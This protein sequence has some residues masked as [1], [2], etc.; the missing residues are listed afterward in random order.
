MFESWGGMNGSS[1][2]NLL[3]RGPASA[4]MRPMG[5]GAAP[6]HPGPRYQRLLMRRCAHQRYTC[7]VAHATNDLNRGHSRR[8]V[9]LDPGASDASRRHSSVATADYHRLVSMELD[10]R[11]RL[12]A[13]QWLQAQM[14]VIGEVL[15]RV[16][17]AEGFVFDGRRV[18]LLGP[19]GIF[20]PA[21]CDMPLSITTS[22]NGPYA[23][24]WT[25]DNRL[26]YA[27]RGTDPAHPDNRG[28]RRAM[29]TR[30]PLAYF[31]GIAPGQ[32]MA[33]F[34][35]YIVGDH[36]AQLSFDVQVDDP[37]HLGTALPSPDMVSEDRAA[38]RR[39]YVTAVVRRRLHQQA[40]RA[41]VIEAYRTRCAFCRLRHQEL[42]DAAHITADAAETGEPVVSN[43][44]ALCKLHHAAFDR[45]FLT[46]RPDYTIEVRRSILDEED[47]PMLLHGLKGMHRQPIYLP[48]ETGLRPDV[49]RLA[50]RYAAFQGAAG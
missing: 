18:P 44:L 22:P 13:F 43:G 32:Y 31:F 47:G 49:D 48:R 3:T 39:E 28:L 16:L 29:E 46:V 34:P 9:R 1:G 17:L 40:F 21:L 45:H 4:P 23:D 27:Y 37:V 30:T 2:A 20:K 38:I 42:L 10:Q 33:S 5:A 11:V 7:P 15:P 41:R 19:Q 6:F 35:V 26:R 12:A 50:E 36:P 25:P 14:D 24:S 8:P